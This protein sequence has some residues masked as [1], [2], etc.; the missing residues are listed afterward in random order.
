MSGYKR[1]SHRFIHFRLSTNHST[2]MTFALDG[3]ERETTSDYK[4]E[5]RRRVHHFLLPRL[6]KFS[7][8]DIFLD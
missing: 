8:V 6:F 7:S 3:R 4:E 5:N 2:A 1:R